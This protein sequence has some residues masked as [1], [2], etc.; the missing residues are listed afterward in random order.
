V[1]RRKRESE[2]E[3]K[4]GGEEGRVGGREREREKENIDKRTHANTK[5]T[6]NQTMVHREREIERMASQGVDMAVGARIVKREKYI[7]IYIYIYTYLIRDSSQ[8]A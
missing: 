1:N 5:K 8:C 4:T 6:K 7:Y 2:G 3:R